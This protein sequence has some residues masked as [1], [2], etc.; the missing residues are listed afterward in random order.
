MEAAGL[1]AGAQA[2]HLTISGPVRRRIAIAAIRR[3]SVFSQGIRGPSV[4]DRLH[5]GRSLISRRDVNTGV[6]RLRYNSLRAA[7]TPAA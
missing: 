4:G 1:A 7:G 3:A 5:P 2:Q 6:C